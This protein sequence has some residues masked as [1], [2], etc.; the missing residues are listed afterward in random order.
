MLKMKL[1]MCIWIGNRLWKHR[2]EK[3]RE[4][5]IVELTSIALEL[6]TSHVL[7]RRVSITPRC[8]LLSLLTRFVI[9]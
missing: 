8:F 2:K 4:A 7:V 3:K 6:V 5:K 9:T 1:I